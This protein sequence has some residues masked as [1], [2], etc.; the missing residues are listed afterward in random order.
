M[1]QINVNNLSF[2]YDGSYENVFQNAS[3]SIDTNWKLGFCGRNGRGK[4]TFLNLLLGKYSYKG[5]INS[6]MKFEYF[7]YDIE[8]KE[9]MTID[10]VGD[11]WQI[12]RE[13]SLLDVDA[14]VLY[15]E[16]NTLS[17]GEQTKVL[18][19]SLFIKENSFL[20]IDE[21][22]NHLD[23]KAR[24]I[25]AKYLNT[26][27][28]FI[29]VS[30]DRAF[31]DECTDHI[32]SINKN[33]IEIT[34]GNFSV[35]YENKVKKDSFELSQNEKLKKEISRL[36]ESAKEK[37]KWAD[38]AEGK[39]IGFDPKKTEKNMGMRSYL[40]AKAKAGMK[41][42]KAIEERQNSAIEEKEGLLKD[43]ETSFDLKIFPQKFHSKRLVEAKDLSISFG[44]KT[45]FSNLNFTISQ[46]DL[47]AI[48]G[49]NGSGKSS[50]IKL[51]CGEDISYSGEIFVA[52][53]LVISTV[54]Q[55]TGHLSGSLSDYEES[56]NIDVSLF[57]TILR[58][59]DFS[60]AL[61]DMNLE[62]FSAG[63]KKK[64]LIAHS[65]STKAHL[66][67]WDEPLNY[68]D[69]LSRMQIE[70][71]LKKYN[72]TMVFVEHDRVFTENIATKI[73]EI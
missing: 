57:R 29:L 25:V 62:S 58:K 6:N 43:I 67:I 8:D 55:D 3:F 63:E 33:S 60:R 51:I 10:I 42:V 34:R 15:R 59:L 14:D 22:T 30:H 48:N 73:I 46:G 65:L 20:L 71:L 31:L 7:P 70:D 37:E 66:Y 4:T 24:E 52:K 38:K 35:W 45:V 11:D 1:S 21:P 28:G 2:S 5:N 17:N 40:G 68:I 36:R 49:K 44:E 18:L 69:I 9:Q 13:L 23:V 26:K 16:F 50:I 47:I 56:N 53:G 72:P 61:F 41:R 39:K 27:K 32:L 19:A 54:N 12:F 64:V